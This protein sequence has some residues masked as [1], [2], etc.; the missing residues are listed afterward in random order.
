MK[1]QDLMGKELKE[2]LPIYDEIS[3]R[4]LNGVHVKTREHRSGFPA[5]TVDC[6]EIHILT[7]CLSME[8]YW[9]ELTQFLKDWKEVSH[10]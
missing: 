2:K 9:G 1:R 5:I 4:H 8:K 7:D 6:E 3:R 10:G